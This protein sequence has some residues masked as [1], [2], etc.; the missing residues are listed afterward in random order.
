MNCKFRGVIYKISI[1]TVCLNCS[2]SIERTCVSIIS[3]TYSNFEWI[4]I[5]G[6]SV[7]GT[8]EVL[9]NYK[10]KMTH[11]SSETDSGIYEAMNKGIKKST[12]EYIIFLNAGDTFYDQDTL[13]KVSQYLGP[14]L[15]Y[16]GCI[17]SDGSAYELVSYPESLS[18]DY[19]L[20][21]VISH[22]STY[23]HKNLF[24]KWGLYDESYKIAGDYEMYARLIQE[25]NFTY[26][27]IDEP[28]SIFFLDG[29][30]NSPNNRDRLKYEQHTLRLK[31][32]KSL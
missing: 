15:L 6:N 13:G 28:L 11:L 30:S 16:G 9:D 10:E 5:D 20:N 8:L 12:G 1:I 25:E 29:I 17:K 14:D 4:V 26:K 27:Q 22:Q 23:Y 24:K 19:F 7:D 2:S 21:N 3:Q 31:Y 32:F 18:D